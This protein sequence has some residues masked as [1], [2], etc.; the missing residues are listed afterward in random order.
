MKDSPERSLNELPTE[1]L[2]RVFV[3][4][5]NPSFPQVSRI[6]ML[7][8]LNPTTRCEWLL[9]R[10][11]NCVSTA[12]EKGIRWPFFNTKVLEILE[13]RLIQGNEPKISV[14]ILMSRLTEK[15]KDGKAKTLENSKL[16]DFEKG[17]ANK[18]KKSDTKDDS[19]LTANNKRSREQTSSN[20]EQNATK[21]RILN[22]QETHVINYTEL[23]I[24]KHIFQLDFNIESKMALLQNLLFRNLSLQKNGPFGLVMACKK[25]NY[26]LVELLLDNGVDPDYKES[27]PIRIACQSGDKGLADILI[28]Y[29]AKLVPIAVR[30]AIKHGHLPLAEHLISKGAEVDMQTINLLLKKK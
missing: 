9:N 22:I 18:N 30:L 17:E 27:L 7:L 4:S 25:A 23:S 24:P 29:N 14:E 12:I 15:N 11:N 26:T 1:L 2:E 3:E 5:N 28:R 6:F 16:T 10:Y 8:S 13:K 21:K 19:I 20:F